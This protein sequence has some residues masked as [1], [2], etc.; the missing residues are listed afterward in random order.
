MGKEAQAWPKNYFTKDLF[1]PSVSCSLGS[2]AMI[3]I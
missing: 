1:Y 3:K 2:S